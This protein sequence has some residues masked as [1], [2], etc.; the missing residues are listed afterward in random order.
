MTDAPHRIPRPAAHP[1]RHAAPALRTW[2][3]PIRL[4]GYGPFLAVYLRP[5]RLR[6]ALLALLLLGGIGLQLANPQILRAFIDTAAAGG[7]LEALIATALLFLGVAL[8]GQAVTVAETYVAESVAWTATNHLRADLALH[9]LR[10]DAAFHSRHTPGELLERIDGDVSK[11]G[12]FFSR[13]IVA[14]LGNARL[15]LGI[16]FLLFRV[17][18]RVGFALS[19][20]VI[21][22]FAVV[23]A[24]GGVAVP[25]W[26]AARAASA[27]L[28]GFLEERFSGTEDL[29]ANG[30]TRYALGRLGERAQDLLRAQRRATVFGVTLSAAMVLL[31]TL[32]TALAVGLG[33]YL[34]RRGAITIGTVYLLYAYAEL[35]RRPL[36]Q[37]TRQLQDLQ[38]AAAGLARVRDLLHERSAVRDG[39]GDPLPAGPLAVEF[40]DVSFTYPAEEAAEETGAGPDRSHGPTLA[41]LSFRLEPGQIL[42]LLGRTGSGKTTVARLL[43][44]LYDPDRGA[45]RLGGTDLCA[46][47]LAELRARVG[48]VSQDIQ[49]FHA[50]VRD[51]LT[52]FDQG[53][54]DALIRQTLEELGL[55]RWCRALP[56]GLDTT[57]APGGEGLSAGEAQL[58]A[59]ARVFLRDPGLVI[60]DEA[61]SRLDP[62]TEAR[63]ARAVDRLLAGRTGIIIAHRLTTVERA[64][65][66]L[67]LEGGRVRE[68]GARA[69]LAADPGSHFARLLRVGLEEAVA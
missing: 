49:F 40:R 54:P 30:A 23:R 4:R 47:R 33:V 46:A 51:N 38:Q 44:R 52:F 32:G 9:C 60:L 69:E 14:L 43:H 25:H 35:L 65:A 27:A 58:L 10:L 28:F 63:V 20:F 17:D 41:D 64:D 57:L 45:I 22:T 42:G 6:V 21:V 36:E 8:A 31:F 62:A 16:L 19:A 15:L 67:I 5:Q 53:I 1:A 66:I 2:R 12:N 13:F 7:S 55:G 34:Y 39:P 29:R 61:S 48:V 11:L 26:T 56:Q 3:P 59:F 37:I 68:W 50:T 18:P 24:L